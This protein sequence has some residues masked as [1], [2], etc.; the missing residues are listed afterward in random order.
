MDFT[1]F[2]LLESRVTSLLTRIADADTRN[3]SLENELEQARSRVQE[4]TDERA[5]I[6]VKIDE[7][8]S[9]LDTLGE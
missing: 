4:L 3:K 8:L 1:K 5:A 2:D 7:L 6:L 9:R